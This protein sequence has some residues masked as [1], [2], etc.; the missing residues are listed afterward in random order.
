MQVLCA[1]VIFMQ[2]ILCFILDNV[3]NCNDVMDCLQ[4]CSPKSLTE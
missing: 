4:T 1:V 2:R 3:I